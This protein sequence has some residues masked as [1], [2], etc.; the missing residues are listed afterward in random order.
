MCFKDK[1]R[2]RESQQQ[3]K[4]ERVKER[5][6][7]HIL[8]KYILAF[9]VGSQSRSQLDG[10]CQVLATQLPSEL[11]R[12]S[13]LSSPATIVAFFPTELGKKKNVNI[14]KSFLRCCFLH[15]LLC[16]EDSKRKQAPFLRV[17]PVCEVRGP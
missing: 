10:N 17:I 12:E 4:R 7:V 13:W 16:F 9:C 8:V 15:Y 14:K 3:K 6:T 5:G 2:E 11:I 1:E